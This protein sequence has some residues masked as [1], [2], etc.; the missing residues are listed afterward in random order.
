MNKQRS[1]SV[2]RGTFLVVVAALLALLSLV[3]LVSAQDSPSTVVEFTLQT[4]IGGTPV[5]SYLGVGGSIDGVVNPELVANVGDTVKITL[6]NGVEMAHDLALSDFAVSTGE[7]ALKG[8]TATVEFVADKTGVFSYH[9]AIPGY[10]ET[11]LE[12]VFR[13]IDPAAAFPMANVVEYTVMTQMPGDPAMAFVGVGG[14][15]DGVIN[16]EL[17]ANLGDT[18]R[19]T[20]INGD[21]MQHDLKIDEFGVYSGELLADEQT[22]TVEFVADQVGAFKYYCSIPGH[23]QIGMEG[24]LKVVG[25]VTV[26]EAGAMDDSKDDGY[27]D[28]SH[29]HS[30]SVDAQTVKPAVEGAVSIIRNPAD[31]PAPIGDREPQHHRIEMT[32]IEVDGVLADGTT[33]RYMT[34]DGQV[35]GPMLRMRVGDTAELH[36]HN[37]MESVLPHSIDLHAV[38]G[39]GGGAVFTQTMVG[40][41][42]VFNFKALQPGLYVY[43]CATASIGHHISSG[44]YGLI[45]IEPEGGLPPVDHEFYIMQGE[46]YTAQPFGTAGHLDFDYQKMLNEQPEYYVFNGAAGALT[47]DEYAMR[48]Q[49]GDTVRVYFGVG[50]PNA[51]SSFHLI[52]EIFDRVYDQASLTSAPLTDVQTTLVPPGGATVVEFT[53]DVPGRYIFVDHALSRLERGL[54]GF[55]YAEGEENPEIFGSSNL[56]EDSGH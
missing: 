30:A 31:L 32:A 53:M 34:F 10:R 21:P 11:G 44:M 56:P 14:D 29:D 16:P 28:E 36:L 52:G 7:L 25:S 8:D 18:V 38:T 23:R 54:V 13:V 27:A 33:Y 42:S 20:V 49:V 37:K 5:M 39:P 22:V 6:I 45:L 12:G 47:L 41:E 55:L 24:V 43:H 3:P 35:P 15:I 2:L 50:G 19:I 1:I 4:Q 48:T 51:I 40:E 17:T 46:I 9:S 26:G